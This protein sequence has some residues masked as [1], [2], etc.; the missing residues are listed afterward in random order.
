M[1][2]ALRGAAGADGTLRFDRF[3]EIALYAPEVGYYAHAGRRLGGSG[4]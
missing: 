2:D 4:D 1:H 3:L